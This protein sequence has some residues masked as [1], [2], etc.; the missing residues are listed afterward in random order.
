MSNE[1]GLQFASTILDGPL[2]RGKDVLEVGA[3]DVNGSIRGHVAALGPRRYVGVDIE[4]GPGVDEVLPAQR[5]VERFGEGAFDVVT[6]M[7]MMEHVRPWREVLG[8]IK[9]VLRPGGTLIITTRSYGF[10]YHG[11]PYDFWRY[12]LSDMRLIFADFQIRALVSDPVTPGVFLAAQ[13]TSDAYQNLD[14]IRLYSVVTFRRSRGVSD[15]AV[16]TFRFRSALRE[17]VRACLPASL[18]NRIGAAIRR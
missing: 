11:Y 8:N 9:R 15:L 13:K 10:G 4:A 3:R 1:S 14:D 12:E 18:T 5:L 7:E 16:R 6:S 17:R 2:V